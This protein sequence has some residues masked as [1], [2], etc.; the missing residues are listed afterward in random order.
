M[1]ADNLTA[2]AD[3][4]AFERWMIDVRQCVVG[5]SD[6]YP[7]GIERDAWQA[8]QAG[9]ANA[10][11]ALLAARDA[12]RGRLL[13][14]LSECRQPVEYKRDVII[15]G[16]DHWHACN[17]LLAAIDAALQAD[18]ARAEGEA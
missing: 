18:T 2:L 10:R 17:Q 11:T 9:A 3:R 13:A 4:A 7:A 8:W 16:C 6:P 15:E 12:E 1:T 5:S 14:L